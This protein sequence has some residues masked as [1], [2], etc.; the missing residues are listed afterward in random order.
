MLTHGTLTVGIVGA[1]R[2]GRTL[3]RGLRAAGWRVGPVVT[4][5]LTTARQAVRAIGDGQPHAALT[6]QLLA[7]DLVLVC[8]PDAEIAGLAQRLAEMGGKEWRGRIVLHVSGLLDSRELWPLGE[9][10]AATGTLHPVQVFSL[11]GITPLDG[12]FFEIEGTATATRAAR[13]ICRELGGVPLSVSTAGKSACYAARCFVCPLLAAS[14][15][16]GTRILM[17]QGLTRRQA[18]RV[19]EPLARRTLDSG[20]RVGPR[21]AASVSTRARRARRIARCAKALSRF[22]RPYRDAYLAL[23]RL[24]ASLA[25]S[26]GAPKKS[27]AAVPPRAFAAAV[28]ERKKSEGENS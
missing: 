13:R 21:A 4:R 7:A 1:G 11:R 25:E 19:L 15:E 20:F 10:G 5:R 24:R 17:A 18:T 23:E 8:V 6:Q 3:G 28:G 27:P 26:G 22:P 12:C 14:F 16:T 2:V 9:C